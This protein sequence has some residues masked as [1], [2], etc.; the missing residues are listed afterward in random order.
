MISSES[1]KSLRR[2]DYIQEQGV[3]WEQTGVL[4]TGRD[5]L[6]LNGVKEDKVLKTLQLIYCSCHFT[7]PRTD[8]DKQSDMGINQENV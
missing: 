7:G 5:L 1:L 3:C 2:L 6:Q 4:E 8:I